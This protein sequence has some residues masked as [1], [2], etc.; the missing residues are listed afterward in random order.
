[1]TG[2]SLEG[3]PDASLPAKGPGRAENGNIV[4]NEFE[5]RQGDRKVSWGVVT[6]SHSQ[7]KYGVAGVTDGNQATGW[8]LLP[9][10]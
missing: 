6:A 10:A 8:A 9:R 3:L 4:L 1:M 5:V 7:D 2:L